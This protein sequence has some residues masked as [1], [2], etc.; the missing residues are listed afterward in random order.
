MAKRLSLALTACLVLCMATARADTQALQSWTGE[1]KVY[2]PETT[3]GWT[4]TLSESCV[5]TYLGLADPDLMGL[6]DNHVVRIWDMADTE[7][8]AVTVPA[9]PSAGMPWHWAA[10]PTPIELGPGSY[11]IGAF[12]P[13]LADGAWL[14]TTDLVMASGVTYGESRFAISDAV[15]TEHEPAFDAG[16]F[17][18]NFRFK[19]PDAVPEPAALNEAQ[20]SIPMYTHERG[21]PWAGLSG[22]Y[23]ISKVSPSLPNLLVQH[24]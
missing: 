4:F 12:Y 22:D 17:G 13:S 8:A 23:S 1:I 16:M 14:Q 18:P 15:P 11:V 9:T 24:T 6:A 5:V 2:I 7:L 20:C 19:A 10:L 21:A 3:L